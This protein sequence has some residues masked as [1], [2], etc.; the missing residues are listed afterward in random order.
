[1]KK[2]GFMVNL[3]GM[4]KREKDIV[5]SRE[6]KKVMATSWTFNTPPILQSFS[7]GFIDYL[8]DYLTFQTQSSN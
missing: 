7:L 2:V 5:L 4:R 1:M 8:N 3:G 6:E